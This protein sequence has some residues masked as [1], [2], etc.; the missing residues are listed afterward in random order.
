MSRM[1]AIRVWRYPSRLEHTPLAVR[2]L[3]LRDL[4]RLRAL[5]TPDV[6]HRC[7]GVE[8]AAFASAW[9]L[10]RWLWAT[11]QMFYVLE[12]EAAGGRLIGFI[13][14]YNVRAGR[15]VWLALGVFRPSDRRHGYGRRALGL[16]CAA[17]DA[18][19]LAETVFVEVRKDNVPSLT[20]FARLGFEVCRDAGDQLLLRKTLRDPSI[21][22]TGRVPGNER[23]DLSE[24]HPRTR[25]RTSV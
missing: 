20:L 22:L 17:L 16:M 21:L 3:R 12:V 11:F 6:L 23:P 24:A 19:A 7:T 25:T 14:L 1:W 18:S 5:L 10:C 8:L 9:A 2:R 15:S 4:P 13:G